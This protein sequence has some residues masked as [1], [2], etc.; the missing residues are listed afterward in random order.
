MMNSSVVSYHEAVLF[1]YGLII[2]LVYLYLDEGR[3]GSSACMLSFVGCS[4]EGHSVVPLMTCMLVTFA[5]NMWLISCRLMR[6]SRWMPNH[7]QLL[8]KI[9]K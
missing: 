7:I 9:P 4:H 5:E 2:V 3:M 1:D 8:A 6:L